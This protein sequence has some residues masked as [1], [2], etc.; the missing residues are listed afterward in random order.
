[1]VKYYKE[2][3]DI[4]EVP[5]GFIK[6]NE[7]GNVFKFGTFYNPKTKQECVIMEDGD[8]ERDYKPEV[9]HIPVDKE[10][11]HLW[12]HEKGIISVGDKVK[13]LKGRK[14]PI[15]TVGLVVGIRKI[16]NKYGAHMC[17]YVKLDNGM[18][19]SVDNCEMI[20]EESA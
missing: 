13:V 18:E 14:V 19:T 3:E 10:V 11:R 1:M 7:S 12:L 16:V 17:D 2:F 9:L 8:D 4:R 5:E 20:K 6:V 15:G